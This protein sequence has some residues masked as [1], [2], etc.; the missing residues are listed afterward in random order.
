MQVSCI[1]Y[2]Y[3]SDGIRMGELG[4]MGLG[5]SWFGHGLMNR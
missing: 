5:R 4:S 2:S 1:M 3:G